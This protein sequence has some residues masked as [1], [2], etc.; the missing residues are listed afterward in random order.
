MIR[1]FAAADKAETSNKHLEEDVGIFQKYLQTNRST[2]NTTSKI[3]VFV[4]SKPSRNK[5][6]EEL[7]LKIENRLIKSKESVKDPDIYFDR[8]LTYRQEVKPVF[9]KLCMWK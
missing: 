1:F 8:N 6:L 2:I 9:A 5:E 4:F 7:R 3:E